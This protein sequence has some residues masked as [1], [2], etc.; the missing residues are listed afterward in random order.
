MVFVAL[1]FWQKAPIL[2]DD[3][4]HRLLGVGGDRV[5][6][7]PAHDLVLKVVRRGVDTKF[8]FRH[9]ICKKSFI[10]FNYRKKATKMNLLSKMQ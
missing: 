2:T 5:L 3:G 10:T 7:S 8:L 9:Q 4:V 1:P 6:G